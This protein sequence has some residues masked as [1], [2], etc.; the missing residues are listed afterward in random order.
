M[1]RRQANLLLLLALIVQT[2][3]CLQSDQMGNFL[4]YPAQHFQPISLHSTSGFQANK[5]PQRTGF[6][7]QPSFLAQPAPTVPPP[8]SP[9][10]PQAVQRTINSEKCR[11]GAPIQWRQHL[12]ASSKA[13]LS[14]IVVWA[15]LKNV[16]TVPIQLIGHNQHVL[17]G[18]ASS[19]Q[20]HAQNVNSDGIHIEA[21]FQLVQVIK[22][23]RSVQVASL[24]R[25]QTIKLLYK[26]SASLSTTNL[27]MTLANNHNQSSPRQINVI[28][29]H[30]SGQQ[31]NPLCALELS[32]SELIKMG[33]KLFKINQDYVLFLD[34]QP[35]LTTTS[36]TPLAKQ[37]KFALN[38]QQSQQQQQHQ[39]VSLDQ[40]GQLNSF[41]LHEA[42]NNQ[43]SRAI[44]RVLNCKTCG[45]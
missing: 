16:S 20:F 23:P 14:P 41:A 31:A 21:T 15:T 44:H 12:D 9:P 7:A 4:M 30:L 5:Y 13:Y 45:K 35:A 6:S 39:Q 2:V 38:K 22:K 10:S 25:A 24:R 29:H 26:V 28:N 18:P 36:L 11:L 40:E 33:S 43:T 8:P 37:R 19:L 1:S 17:S 34:Q 32:E 42:V 27:I 3:E